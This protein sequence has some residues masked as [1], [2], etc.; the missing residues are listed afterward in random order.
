MRPPPPGDDSETANLA[1]RLVRQYLVNVPQQ[2]HTYEAIAL[3]ASLAN[4]GG[5]VPAEELSEAVARVC[6]TI[7]HHLLGGEKGG[8]V[9]GG[10]A[11]AKS[12]VVVIESIAAMA[13]EAVYSGRQDHWLVLMRGLRE[14]V[15]RGGGMRAEWGATLNKIRK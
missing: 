8:S 9:G 5:K 13:M 11:A 15:D 2:S 14:I 4:G 3:V 12:E 10:A 1:Q 6:A 7:N